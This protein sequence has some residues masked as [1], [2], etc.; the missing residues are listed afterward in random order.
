MPALHQV[1]QRAIKLQPFKA[2]GSDG[3]PNVAL[4]QSAHIIAPYL[5]A[6]IKL[7]YFAAAWRT[8][9]TIVLPKPG[10]ADYTIP[11]AYLPIALYNTMGR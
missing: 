8:W 11:K 4:K 7:K 2:P 1:H 5:Q 10:R 6:I 3:I 9:T